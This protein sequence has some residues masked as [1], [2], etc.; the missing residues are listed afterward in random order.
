MNDFTVVATT[1]NLKDDFAAALAK[2]YNIKRLGEHST[3][4]GWTVK[5]HKNGDIHISQPNAI[6]YIVQQ[7]DMAKCNAKDTPYCDGVLLLK[8]TDKDETQMHTQKNTS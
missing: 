4:L 7:A 6:K 2:A 5:R 3:F 8:P 1:A